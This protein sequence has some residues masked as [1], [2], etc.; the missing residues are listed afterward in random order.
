MKIKHILV[1][2]LILIV[3]V[4]LLA[5]VHKS[6]AKSALSRHLKERMLTNSLN[7]S[8]SSQ[9]TVDYRITEL[10]DQLAEQFETDTW[11]NNKF[12][13]YVFD[14]NNFVVEIIEKRY[15]VEEND[16]D[17]NSAAISISRN[18]IGLVTNV[19]FA[20]VAKDGTETLLGRLNQEYNENDQVILIFVE[21]FDD[22][23][24]DWSPLMEVEFGYGEDNR[25][26]YLQITQC[27]EEGIDYVLKN[28]LFYDEQGRLDEAVAEF[29]LDA[30][31]LLLNSK[32]VN[33]YDDSDTS[34]YEKM[35]NILNNFGLDNVFE[36]GSRF[37]DRTAYLSEKA[38]NWDGEEYIL[39]RVTRYEYENQRL[40]YV[41]HDEFEYQARDFVTNN[42]EFYVHD[43]KGLMTEEH[44]QFYDY[45]LEKWRT[46][47]RKV[48]TYEEYVSADEVTVIPVKASVKNYPNP[49]NPETTISFNLPQDQFVEVAVYNTK[50]QLVT[51]LISENRSSGLNSVIWYGTDSANK[52]MPS[53]LYFYRITGKNLS[54][55]G[56][57]LMLK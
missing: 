35:Q 7:F 57:M 47:S 38:Y 5:D 29:G 39:N 55:K 11:I 6:E 27:S 20:E 52:P 15:N 40:I 56:K 32:S 44:Q 48:A 53:G 4:T 3:S 21:I 33:E 13:G 37:D 54:M 34:T 12:R 43:D 23:I 17:D 2:S 41:Y 31:T 50:G 24:D 16:W 45:N 8:P 42:R 28:S 26:E 30:D 46:Y 36:L 10:L 49:F 51:K 9:L 19:M 22:E 25:C 18:E 1:L 14:E